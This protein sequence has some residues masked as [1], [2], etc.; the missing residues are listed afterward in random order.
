MLKKISSSV[1]KGR[2]KK[3]NGETEKEDRKQPTPQ[4]KPNISLN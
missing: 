4:K 3:K 2:Q 1:Q